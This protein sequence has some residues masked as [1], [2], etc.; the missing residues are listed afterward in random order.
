MDDKIMVVFP[1]LFVS[2]GGGCAR[3]PSRRSPYGVPVV[4]A[5][6]EAVVLDTAGTV[7]GYETCTYTLPVTADGTYTVAVSSE[8]TGFVF[9][10]RD[11]GGNKVARET[12][13][14]WTGKLKKGQYTVTVGLMRDVPR[15]NRNA[16]RYTVEVKRQ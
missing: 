4:S 2:A 8:N 15:I 13:R 6:P 1:F 12:Y 16:V 14:A 11:A 10:V 9:V 7:T 5:Q 3:K